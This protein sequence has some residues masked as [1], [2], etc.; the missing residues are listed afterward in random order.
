MSAAEVNDREPLTVQSVQSLVFVYSKQTRLVALA[1]QKASF[2]MSMLAIGLTLLIGNVSSVMELDVRVQACFAVMASIQLIAIFLAVWTV[3]PRVSSSKN[4]F[5][6]V[7]E[8]SNPFF[9]MLLPSIDEDVYTNGI[10]DRLADPEEIARM[11]ITD[12]YQIG[13]SLTFK[14]KVLRAAYTAAVMSFAPAGL[15]LVLLSFT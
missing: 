5:N 4:R 10:L 1:D 13:I 15:G 8:M 9:F 12:F 7:A 3:I 11:V 6:S 14:Y 2:L